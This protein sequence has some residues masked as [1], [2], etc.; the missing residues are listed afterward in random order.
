M[1]DELTLK[2]LQKELKRTKAGW[3]AEDNPISKLSPAERKR[4]LG[5]VPGAEEMSL[6][7]REAVSKQ[8]HTTYLEARKKGKA[9]ALAPAIDWRNVGGW[10]YVTPVQNQGSCGS[11]VAFGTVGLLEAQARIF[12]GAPVNGPAGGVLPTLSEAHLFFCGAGQACGTG[13]YNSA[14]L[15][16][17]KD[18]GVCT[19]SCYPYKAKNQ[20]CNPCKDWASQ[21]TQVEAWHGISSTA[22]MKTWLSTKGPLLTAFTVYSDFYNYKSGVYKHTSGKVEG[23]HA[24][25]CVG[26]SETLQAWLCKNSWGGSWGMSGYFWIGYGQCGIDSYMQAVDSFKKIYPLYMDM[27]MRDSLADIGKVPATGTLSHSP[28]IVPV[29]TMPLA[30]PK[31]TLQG[32]WYKDI[33]QNLQ[34]NQYN[35]IYLRGRSLYPT[36]PE[37]G[38]VSLFYTPA[39]LIMWPQQWVKNTIK[40]EQG[41]DT[42]EFGNTTFGEI[43]TGSEPFSWDPPPLANSGDHYCLISRVAT[44]G[45]P[46]PVPTSFSTIQDFINWVANNPG[47]AWR[48]VVLVN[49]GGAPQIQVR[50]ALTVTNAVDLYI[51]LTGEGVTGSSAACACGVEGPDPV[52]A[53]NRT[54]FTQEGEIIGM[55]TS[56]PANFT[57]PLTVS[58]W[59]NG[60]K[61]ADGS[62]V[63]VE[64]FYIPPSPEEIDK[65]MLTTLPTGKKEKAGVGP[66]QAVLVGS[67]K[68]EFNGNA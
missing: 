37:T 7:K 45:H 39:S 31:A 59:N 17:A 61:P 34:A 38:T 21:V 35:Y 19:D 41:A 46:D 23:G 60:T 9:L 22:D 43:V 48:N 55:T 47:V 13:W 30:D 65:R 68:I 3:E 18:T 36:P 2:A 27:I 4:R 42:V 25:C 44:T 20:P 29:G 1:A 64:A 66:V 26:Y 62:S 49:P 56:V 50:V 12:A 33:G 14:A 57:G 16:F 51:C 58:W 32:N 54:E 5:Y 8:A 40:T 11:C 28:D 24:V 67:Y 52:I 63:M 53:I 15:N 10:N 6:E